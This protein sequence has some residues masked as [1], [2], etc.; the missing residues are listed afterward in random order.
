[1][2]PYTFSSFLFFLLCSASF[3]GVVGQNAAGNAPCISTD[4]LR[5]LSIK[6]ISDL[7]TYYE[8]KHDLESHL[9]LD[10]YIINRKLKTAEDSVYAVYAYQS[11]AEDFRGM[12]NAS[13]SIEI[14]KRGLSVVRYNQYGKCILYDRIAAAFYE[15][16]NLDSAQYY[17]ALAFAIAQKS[18]DPNLQPVLVRVGMLWGAIEAAKGNQ[19]KALKIYADALAMAQKVDSPN[20]APLYRSM[21]TIHQ[22]MGQF[23]KSDSLFA[24]ALAGLD[25]KQDPTNYKVTLNLWAVLKAREGD[26][27]AAYNL[28]SK[29]DS[30]LQLFL[31]QNHRSTLFELQARFNS[32]KLETANTQLKKLNQEGKSKISYQYGII[33]MGMILLFAGGLFGFSQQRQKKKLAKESKVLAESQAELQKQRKV[34]LTLSKSQTLLISVISHDFRTPFNSLS[35]TIEL[36]KVN[37][38]SGEERDQLLSSISEQVRSSLSLANDILLWAKGQMQG[39]IPVLLP[40]QL[41]QHARKAAHQ[42]SHAAHLKDVR[43]DCQNLEL[44]EELAPVL[45]DSGSLD[46]VIRNILSNAI[47]FTPAHSVVTIK[48]VHAAG[49]VG[50]SIA[51]QGDGI[52]AEK[53]NEITKFSEERVNSIRSGS[54]FGSGLG[55]VLVKDFLDAMGGQLDIKSEK[56]QGAN[57]TFWLGK[58]PDTYRMVEENADAE[59]QFSGPLA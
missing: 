41:E 1:M 48:I 35:S 17:G 39:I 2:R 40:L 44:G 55:L 10:F 27:K 38:L 51:D 15:L 53:I 29:R 18:S 57:I 16:P 6:Q 59:N 3:A 45:A 47:K 21:A 58:A 26:Y 19:A 28:V 30:V 14:G 33:L 4:C 32:E 20:V 37:A 46:I 49:Q 8:D 24:L 9:R 11:I 52:S 56:G 36:L 5:R 42:L 31:D 43:I 7:Q 54:D 25:A 12:G 50:L 13:K 22:T 23:A 34:L